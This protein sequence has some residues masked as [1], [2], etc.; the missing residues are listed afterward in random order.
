MWEALHFQRLHRK[1]PVS[2]GT[3][4]TDQESEATEMARRVGDRVLGMSLCTPGLMCLLP[5]T[6][7]TTVRVALGNASWGRGSRGRRCSRAGKEGLV[8][9]RGT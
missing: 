2:P 8:A 1:K 3:F 5:S 7:I 6:P 4:L 9:L